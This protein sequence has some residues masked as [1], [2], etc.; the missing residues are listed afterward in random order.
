MSLLDE[1]PNRCE[2]APNAVGKSVQRGCC[3]DWPMER[4]DSCNSRLAA[5]YESLLDS[6]I[7]SHDSV[8]LSQACV[9][10]PLFSENCPPVD[11][12]P[13]LVIPNVGETLDSP[14]QTLAEGTTAAH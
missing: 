2:T 14:N 13:L 9:Y 12:M 10:T 8:P 7:I 1:L 11:P 3:R 4:I 6:S 5:S